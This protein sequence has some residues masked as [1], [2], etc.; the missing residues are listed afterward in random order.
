[1]NKEKAEEI[2]RLARRALEAVFFRIREGEVPVMPY[3]APLASRTTI[4]VTRRPLVAQ[5]TPQGRIELGARVEEYLE[6]ALAEGIPP[7]AAMGTLIAHEVMHI[8]LE[9]W[10]R[11]EVW[12]EAYPSWE[13]RVGTKGLA[14]VFNLAEDL[15]INQTLRRLGFRFESAA[16]FPE[17][18]A[19]P[20]P[21]DLSVEEYVAL[22]LQQ[23]PP[24]LEGERDEA[25]EGESQGEEAPPNAEAE[26]ES[27]EPTEDEDAGEPMGGSGGGPEG[28]PGGEPEEGEPDEGSEEGEPG[29]GPEEDGVGGKPK[30]S[31]TAED[32]GGTRDRPQG[33]SENAE[34]PLGSFGHDAFSGSQ[35]L[36]PE[37]VLAGE[38]GAPLGPNGEFLKDL[39]QAVLR[40]AS[41]ALQRGVGTS[42]GEWLR[43]FERE[44]EVRKTVPWQAVLRRVVRRA[45]GKARRSPRG[46]RRTY[47]HP[48]EGVRQAMALALGGAYPT[49]LKPRRQVRL[50]RIGL[51]WDTSGSTFVLTPFHTQVRAEVEALLEEVGELVVYQVDAD[52]R[53]R[54]QVRALPQ[55]LEIAGGGGT[56]MSVGIA[57]AEREGVDLC[58][59]A[60]DG[61]TPWP[62][63]RPRIPVVVLLV[64]GEEELRHITTPP[65]AFRIEAKV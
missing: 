49:A 10:E 23:S 42:P 1:M 35:E 18:L 11:L 13:K 27:G 38:D 39:R 36:S 22:L 34:T 31:G 6:R 62:E 9:G 7:L 20:V 46:H 45:L 64:G 24:F 4:V 28:E 32:G 15:V 12:R 14:Q 30:E 63:H 57:Q 48:H 59:V 21:S 8:F 26:G 41:E 17:R 2:W 53:G 52:L 19:P 54:F 25:Q 47:P 40:G 56:D 33:S 43:T 50:P 61:Y 16:L 5:I 65:W 51:V 37:D 29:E 55:D 58:V 3:M 44:V 60:T